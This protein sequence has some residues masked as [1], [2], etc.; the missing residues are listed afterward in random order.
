MTAASSCPSAAARASAPAGRS[1]CLE[2]RAVLAMLCR[3]FD[4]EPAMPAGEV[5]EHLAFTM[6]P[7]GLKVRLKRRTAA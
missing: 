7:A 1:R 3:N 5:R 6:L 2:I 4:L